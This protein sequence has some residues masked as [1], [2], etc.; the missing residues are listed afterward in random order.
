MRAKFVRISQKLLYSHTCPD[1][2]SNEIDTKLVRISYQFRAN[3]VQFVEKA[4]KRTEMHKG[5]NLQSQGQAIDQ[6]PARVHLGLRHAGAVFTKCHNVVGQ[7]GGGGGNAGDGK[8]HL[9]LR[10]DVVTSSWRTN[11]TKKSTECSATSI[12]ARSAERERKVG[13]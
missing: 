4:S 12:T 7:T 8:V 5:H 6:A 11:P 2:R 3:Y 10:I 13:W 9:L 1:I